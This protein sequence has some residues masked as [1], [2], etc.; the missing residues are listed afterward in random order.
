MD[1]SREL[2]WYLRD[3]FF[4]QAGRGRTRFE[5]DAIAGEMV[6]LYLRF[7]QYSPD[8]LSESMAPVI[9]SLLSRRVLLQDGG[10]LA[11]GGALERLQCATCYYVSYLSQAEARACQRCAGSNL[12]EFPKKK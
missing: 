4:R 6:S 3:H 7:R 5:R 9:D 1:T 10:A 2:E 11:L 8:Q 12:H